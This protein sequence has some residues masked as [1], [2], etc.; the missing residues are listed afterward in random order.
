MAGQPAAAP[1]HG[2][3]PWSEGRLYEVPAMGASGYVIALSVDLA[4]WV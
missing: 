1:E 4:A 3:L 2:G